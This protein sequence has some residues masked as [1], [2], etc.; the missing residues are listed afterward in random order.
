MK[1]LNKKLKV[2]NTFSIAK[3]D[4]AII[5][6]F[7]EA[8]NERPY[9]AAIVDP[10]LALAE[11]DMYMAYLVDALTDM[12][13]ESG[14]EQQELISKVLSMDRVK[15]VSGM[16]TYTSQ[17]TTDDLCI[18]K[19]EYALYEV[20]GS[21]PVDCIN[22]GSLEYCKQLQQMYIVSKKYSEDDLAIIEIQEVK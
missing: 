7:I 13:Y 8:R 12:Y 1:T 4:L 22:T 9:D 14:P 18:L 3:E 11:Y 19:D 20:E 15:S 6:E 10:E 16:E 5:R 17:E 21:F 2:V